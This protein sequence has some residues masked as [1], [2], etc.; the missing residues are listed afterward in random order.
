VKSDPFGP[1]PTTSRTRIVRIGASIIAIALA[2]VAVRL[3]TRR[4]PE[5]AA[6]PQHDM[7]NM[8]RTSGVGHP[9]QMS[10]ADQQRIGVTFS[11][12][13]V[14][15]LQREIRTVA[16]V[17]YDETR[18]AA[19]SLKVDGWVDQLAVNTPGEAIRKGDPLFAIY[20]P[21][22]VTAQQE[23]LLARRLA[24]DVASGSASTRAGANA[25]YAA[26]H[27]RLQQWDV[28]ESEIASVERDGTAHRTV[29]FLSSAAGV[30][31]EKNVVRGQRIM[32]GET[33]FRIA[34]L[35]RVW[36]D[37]E[38]FGQDLAEVHVGQEVTAEF[39][40][41]PGETRQ[42]RISFIYPT[43]DAETRTAHV[44]VELANPGLLLK[45]G[46]YATIRFS[47]T[48]NGVLTVPR[49]SVLTTGERSL[50]FVRDTDGQFI[51]REV[52]VGESTD[53]RIEILRG[54]KAGEVVVASGTFL[55]DA[56]SNLD[57]ALGGMGNMPGMDVKAPP[58]PAPVTAP[59]R[60]P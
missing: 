47:S 33:L 12:A 15:W 18:I 8:S 35:S 21:M 53:E 17:A 4:P 39:S 42:G 20:S 24:S 5:A 16:Q 37:G 13:A 23:L 27:H 44:R 52:V 29:T 1:R 9:V 31:I 46:M 56:E 30:V 26:A 3:F 10:A 41:L 43:L 2:L 28:P 34:D 36:L 25:L 6:T 60:T 38:V 11:T 57:K 54:L 51:A 22:L 19:V 50:V 48:R 32:A 45:P 14:G 58:P 7:M 55:V 49:S 59:R 40:A